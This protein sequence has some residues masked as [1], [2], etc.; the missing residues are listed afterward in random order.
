MKDHLHDAII[1]PDHNIIDSHICQ[2]ERQLAAKPG[3]NKTCTEKDS[4]P[5]EGGPAPERSGQIHRKFNPFKRRNKRTDTFW[6]KT[7]AGRTQIIGCRL[8]ALAAP[9][10]DDK[11]ALFTTLIETADHLRCR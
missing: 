4:P 5:P 8:L 7:V 6:K 11:V 1:L 3:I 2:A 10:C 9:G